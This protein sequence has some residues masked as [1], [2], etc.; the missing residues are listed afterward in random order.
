MSETIGLT[1]NCEKMKLI[2]NMV[3]S[4]QLQI[5][6]NNIE[7]VDKYVYYDHEIKIMRDNQTVNFIEK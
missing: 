6:N 2:T 4:E 1:T 5:N 7:I 3:L